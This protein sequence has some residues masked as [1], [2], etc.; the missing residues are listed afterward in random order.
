MKEEKR[1][2]AIKEKEKKDMKLADEKGLPL[3]LY[4]KLVKLQSD[5]F[6]ERFEYRKNELIDVL[7]KSNISKKDMIHKLAGI[8]Q[9]YYYMQQMI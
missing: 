8:N 6:I 5:I 3:N 1:L 4:R 7:N 2:A 9:Y